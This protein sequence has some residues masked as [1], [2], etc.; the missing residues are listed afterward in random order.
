VGIVDL[1]LL[2]Q[3]PQKDARIVGGKG[4]EA[5]SRGSTMVG[6]NMLKNP[7]KPLGKKPLL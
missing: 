7:R 3:I 4:E 1:D 6:Q 5:S 2:F